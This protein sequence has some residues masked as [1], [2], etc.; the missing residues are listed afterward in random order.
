MRGCLALSAALVFALM[1]QASADV[2]VASSKDDVEQ[3]IAFLNEVCDGRKQADVPLQDRI[4]EGRVSFITSEPS[5]IGP[6]PGDPS[7]R[8]PEWF[9]FRYIRQG[10]K[11]RYERDA[12][13]RTTKGNTPVKAYRLDDGAAL[14]ALNAFNLEIAGLDARE[15]TWNTMIADYSTFWMVRAGTGQYEVSLACRTLIEWLQQ[16]DPPVQ[17]SGR[18]V[19]CWKND[20]G[21]LGVEIVNSPKY[22]K[23]T[24]LTSRFWID[25][26]QGYNLIS[27][28][29]AM[30]RPEQPLFANRVAELKYKEHAPGVFFVDWAK[31]DVWN[32]A[33]NSQERAHQRFEL[34]IDSLQFGSI[35]VEPNMFDAK[36]LQIA[37]G[38]HVE[39][40]RY[41]PPLMFNFRKK[42]LDEQ[43]LAEAASIVHPGASHKYRWIMVSGVT[44]VVLVLGFRWALRRGQSNPDLS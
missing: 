41:D 26:K 42:P 7:T 40:S 38:A 14:Y 25:P 28:Y 15:T 27:S 36:Q 18:I 44:I 6:P 31:C 33:E 34:V 8:D 13:H 11:A 23:M 12:L 21:Q 3:V 43:I 9:A 5:A 19:N 17:L 39:D 20:L 1:G 37:V 30:F 22:P 35:E 29:E 2:L 4:V 24:P 16:R 32:G 10:D